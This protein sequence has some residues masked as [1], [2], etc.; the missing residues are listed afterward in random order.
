MKRTRELLKKI[1][2]LI[3]SIKS[4]IILSFIY[5]FFL[6]PIAF[7]FKL[8]GRDH[9]HLGFSPELSTYRNQE[10]KTSGNFEKPY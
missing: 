1:I 7:F 9:L 4:K 10:V 2:M 3:A 6:T 5:F 8:I